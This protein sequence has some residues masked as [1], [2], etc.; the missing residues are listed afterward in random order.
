MGG[1]SRKKGRV[2]KSLIDGLRKMEE[3]KRLGKSSESK[4]EE[5]TKQPLKSFFGADDDNV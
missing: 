1:K 3:A 4:K 2:S 5:E